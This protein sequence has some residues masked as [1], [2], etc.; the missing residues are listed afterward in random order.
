MSLCRCARG[1]KAGGPDRGVWIRTPLFL[2]TVRRCVRACVQPRPG[3]CQVRNRMCPCRSA[4]CQYEQRCVRVFAHGCGRARWRAGVGEKGGCACVVQCARAHVAAQCTRPHA[5]DLGTR[6]V[7]LQVNGVV[8]Y[9]IGGKP[10]TVDLKNGDGSVKEGKHA[11]PD[12]TII[13]ADDDFLQLANGKL[14][15]QQ[16]CAARFLWVHL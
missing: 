6:A 11:T 1:A 2:Q 13:V 7:R 16:V 12:V 14:N 9:E 8:L 10:W 5:R 15:P 3:R 4:V